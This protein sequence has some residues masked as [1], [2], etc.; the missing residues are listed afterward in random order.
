M[1]LIISQAIVRR[2]LRRQISSCQSIFTRHFC[3]K[4]SASSPSIRSHVSLLRSFRFDHPTKTFAIS[5]NRTSP[6]PPSQNPVSEGPTAISITVEQ[7][8]QL[9]DIFFEKLVNVLETEQEER[10][11]V[12]VEYSV[13]PLDTC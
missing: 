1:A 9:T 2:P 11:D 12:D 8:H 10:E 7:Y 6:S 3:G 13:W 4:S 5:T